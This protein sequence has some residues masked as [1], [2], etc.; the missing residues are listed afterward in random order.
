M[1]GK[2][3]K[4]VGKLNLFQRVLNRQTQYINELFNQSQ[5][6]SR[7]LLNFHYFIFIWSCYFEHI[8]IAVDIISFSEEISEFIATNKWVIVILR[9]A[10]HKRSIQNPG[11]N[12]NFRK[13]LRI[14]TPAGVRRL[15][16][17]EPTNLRL[18]KRSHLRDHRHSKRW[19]L[20]YS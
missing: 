18:H 2:I 15:V 10:I 16:N 19:Y 4:K 12:N 20:L 5:I 3:T 11:F 13:P 9:K 14:H 7:Q 6:N 8:I 1:V 17:R